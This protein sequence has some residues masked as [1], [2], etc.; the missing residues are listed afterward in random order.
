MIK[1]LLAGTK[2][3]TRRIVKD[4][5]SPFGMWG[6]DKELGMGRIYMPE[7]PAPVGSVPWWE[8]GG[9]NG[10]GQHCPYGK[11]GDRLWV[12]ET[13]NAM[14]VDEDGEAGY[15]YSPIPKEKPS[16]ACIVY[17][18][19]GDDGPFRPSIHMPRWASRINLEIVSIRVERL[20]EIGQGAACSEGCPAG[21]EPIDWFTG[22]WEAI[23][24][25]GSWEKNPWVWVIE[26]RRVAA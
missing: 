19:G 3:Q 21:H 7:E 13:W 26:F 14:P 4:R 12:R 8:L 22:L 5:H 9:I 18:A 11:L 24:G 17:A 23:N 10:A 2:T 6:K 20:Q 16:G 15:P 25:P 1:A